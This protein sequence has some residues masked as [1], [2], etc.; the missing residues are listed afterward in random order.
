MEANELNI[1]FLSLGEFSDLSQ[2]SVH[3]D[4]MKRFA[5]EHNVFL[6]CKC[7]RRLQQDTKLTEEYNIHVLRV[8][9]GNLKR[10]N[11]LEKGISTILV[12]PQFL[13]A[14]KK[15]FDNVKFDLVLY[16][17]PPITFANVVK[18]IKKKSNAVTYLMLKDIF[19][20]NAVDI[21]MLNKSGIKGVIYQ[22]FRRKEK[23]LYRVSDYIGCMS[24][25]NVK[26]ILE[27][28]A[29]IDPS[30]VEVCPNTI[31]AKD[32]SVDSV[33]ELTIRDKYHIPRDKVVFVYGG[34]LG[35]PQGIPY[36]IEC[37][38]KLDRIQKGNP[39]EAISNAFILI[40]GSGTEFN[41]IRSYIDQESPANIRLMS[42]LPG[43]DYNSMVGACDVGMLFLDHRFT[44]PNFPSRV[45]SYM[46]AKLPVLAVTDPNTDVGTVITKGDFGWWC[47]SNKV[48]ITVNTIN[49][50]CKMKKSDLTTMGCNG[51]EYLISKYS[52]NVAY[53][54]IISH[55]DF[56]H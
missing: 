31:N 16:E 27:H 14:I 6:V 53:D 34:N 21:G 10:S 49:D 51:W 50:I 19:P 1:L 48:D 29:W 5:A 8:K 54:A 23:A 4:I 3:I 56:A 33:T 52:V 25:A 40:I 7:E 15:Y 42:S 9:T 43:S 38:R 13:N 41:S 32:M 45:L 17:T 44:I 55:F 28:N 2:S 37:L 30:I 36:L 47:E 26:Y 35:K 18:Y 46:Q 12:E 22:Y 11:L 24:E 20:Q 39:E